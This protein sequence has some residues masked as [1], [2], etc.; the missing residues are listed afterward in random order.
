MFSSWN[1]SAG[2][3][4]RNLKMSEMSRL[5]NT[6]M[7]DPDPT[8]RAVALQMW[9]DLQAGEGVAPGVNFVGTVGKTQEQAQEDIYKKLGVESKYKTAE[10][11]A[12][13]LY[14]MV[15]ETQKQLQMTDREKQVAEINQTGETYRRLL[16]EQGLNFRDANKLVNDFKIEALKAN[17]N[18]ELENIKGKYGLTEKKVEGGYGVKKQELANMGTANVAEI[19]R[20]A[21]TD[22]ANI[23]LQRPTELG[24]KQNRLATGTEAALTAFQKYAKQKPEADPLEWLGKTYAVNMAGGLAGSTASALAA[25][26]V[27]AGEFYRK[28][29]QLK[30]KGY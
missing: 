6:A 25:L 23:N 4:Q 1:D 17:N 11:Q 3:F 7:N 21:G 24:Y 26:G 18:I 16:Q 27:D 28:A 2:A 10:E 9:R 8:K 15:A 14:G 20:Q 22:V 29:Q 30:G 5:S 12:K 19:N 13:A